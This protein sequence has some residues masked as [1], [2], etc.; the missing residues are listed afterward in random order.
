[1]DGALIVLIPISVAVVGLIVLLLWWAARSGQFDDME[2]PAHAILMDDDTPPQPPG[3][4]A[5]VVGDADDRIPDARQETT[6]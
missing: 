6:R 1:M 2:G 5:P 3:E 4:Q